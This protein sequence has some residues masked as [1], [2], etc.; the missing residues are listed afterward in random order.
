MW[1]EIAKGLRVWGFEGLAEGILFFSESVTVSRLITSAF[2]LL[3]LH[4]Q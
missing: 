3:D 1:N 4:L 2:S